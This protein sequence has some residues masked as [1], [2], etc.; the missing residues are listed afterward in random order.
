MIRRALRALPLAATLGA[1]LW[2]LQANPLAAPMVE[3]TATDLARTL[4]RE[5]RRTATPEW[6]TPALA[7][8]VAQQDI[9]RA[10]MLIELIED[11]G[12]DV[13]IAPATAMIAARG[14]PFAAMTDCAACMADIGTCPTLRHLT[15]CA[16][17]FEMSP[18]GDLNA[19]RRA[20]V[21]IATGGDVDTLDAGLAVVGLG[22]TAAVLVSGGSSAT[23]KAG[24][25]L[26]R[27]ARRIGSITPDLARLLRVPVRWSKV[28]D[29]LTGRA[30]AE[31]MIDAVALT[32]IRG[33][34]GDMGRV[35]AAT[36]PAEA[37]RL[38][39]VIDTPEDAARLARIAEAA[40]PRTGRS[41]MVLGKGRVFRATLRLS[42][43][44]TGA[45]V[46]IWLTV[47]QLAVI[48][49]TRVGTL[50]L[51]GMSRAV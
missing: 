27:M 41:F 5:V 34:A 43:A 47:V 7:D 28:E 42:R 25:T 39:R 38:A 23:V 26:L 37:L 33:L 46:L 16:L 12:H 10:A 18:L 40:G 35:A 13:D 4:E 24:A 29:V 11:L 1:L 14:G 6:L 9:D 19:L 44:A 21:E 3:R 8:A 32:R 20:S 31:E 51:R 30:G 50:A 49:G 17:P 36:S 2:A 45:L 15:L 22:A 48:L